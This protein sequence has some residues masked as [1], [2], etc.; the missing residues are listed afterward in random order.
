MPRTRFHF[1]FFT[2]RNIYDY[3]EIMSTP[4]SYTSYDLSTA[5]TDFRRATFPKCKFRMIDEPTCPLHKYASVKLTTAV[6][7]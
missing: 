1:K 4:K 5:K 3:T 7:L 2:L 6:K